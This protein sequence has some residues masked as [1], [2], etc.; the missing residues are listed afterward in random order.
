[1]L[2]DLKADVIEYRLATEGFPDMTDLQECH[3]D[4]VPSSRDG[5]QPSPIAL[6]QPLDQSSLRNRNHHEQD[7]H[8]RDRRK[9]VVV[10]RDDHGLIEGIDRA[11]DMALFAHLDESDVENLKPFVDA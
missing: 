9:I 5:P 3:D 4:A 8:D 1:M 7:R 2:F 6:D 10:A 11:D